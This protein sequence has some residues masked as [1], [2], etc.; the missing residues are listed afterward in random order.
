ME[1]KVLP[2]NLL[3]EIRGYGYDLIRLAPEMRA[4]AAAD[5]TVVGPSG[6]TLGFLKLKDDGF[7]DF[8]PFDP[9][10]D[11]VPGGPNESGPGPR[12]PA[13]VVFAAFC[14]SQHEVGMRG[15]SSDGA[16]YGAAHPLRDDAVTE[17]SQ[18]NGETGHAA[19]V[20]R[21]PEG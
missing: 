3:A 15:V 10:P 5:V 2:D 6:V 19:R 17:A 7:Y 20:G 12:R 8:I 4:H 1:G 13:P 16:W 18:H 11:V 21:Y 14:S 9:I